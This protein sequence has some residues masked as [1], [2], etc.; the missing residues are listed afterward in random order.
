MPAS[1]FEIIL[2]CT[3]F[4]G[5][6]KKLFSPI[7]IDPTIA[8][9]GLALFNFD[10]SWMAVNWVVSGI[11]LL[12]LIVYSQILVTGGASY[13]CCFRFYWQFLPGWL[14]ALK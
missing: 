1:F 6:I 5:L 7:V 11:T 4:M 8:M 9:I 13:S 3:G 10:V 14:V 12:A 2:G